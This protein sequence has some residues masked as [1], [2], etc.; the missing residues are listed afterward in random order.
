MNTSGATTT[1]TFTGSE[2]T[3]GWVRDGDAGFEGL[4]LWKKTSSHSIDEFFKFQTD[5]STSEEFDATFGKW[6]AQPAMKEDSTWKYRANWIL[7]NPPSGNVLLENY[8]LKNV[9]VLFCYQLLFQKC[10]WKK[11]S[12]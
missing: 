12:N 7:A 4:D 5:P 2:D 9:L 10:F 8:L 11:S 3:G 1:Y 6:H